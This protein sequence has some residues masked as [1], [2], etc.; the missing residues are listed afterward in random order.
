[1][2]HTD[3]A[4]EALNAAQDAFEPIAAEYRAAHTSW[5]KR[6]TK[7]TK[8]RYYAS[9]MAFDKAMDEIDALH[10]AVQVA[11]EL[12]RQEEEEAVKALREYE[13]PSLF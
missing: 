8:E 13:Q 1:M 6:K 10:E 9:I 12:D 4:Y 5:K 3:K 11:I 2:S 7:G